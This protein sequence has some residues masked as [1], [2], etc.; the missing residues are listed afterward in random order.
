MHLSAVLG[1]WR[2]AW[3]GAGARAAAEEIDFLQ[4]GGDFPGDLLWRV[5]V[6][7]RPRPMS[8]VYT[9][10][11]HS[12]NMKRDFRKGIREATWGDTLD[13]QVDN[14]SRPC[15]SSRPGGVPYLAACRQLASWRLLQIAFGSLGLADWIDAGVTG[16][17]S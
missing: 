5:P 8:H 12:V 3:G 15:H 9:N 14:V 16:A 1:I 7:Y 11:P 10:F 4:E 17:E 2:S 6:H 13:K